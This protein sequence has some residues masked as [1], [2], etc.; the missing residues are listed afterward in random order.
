MLTRSP[1]RPSK[2][3]RRK[4]RPGPLRPSDADRRR[5]LRRERKKRREMREAAGLAC[6]MVEYDGA[7]LQFLIA[8]HWLAEADADD[9]AKVSAAVGAM[10]RKS[11]ENN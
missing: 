1:S 9:R 8:T 2:R 4:A 11:A 5:E 3:S 7:M 6:C 10:W